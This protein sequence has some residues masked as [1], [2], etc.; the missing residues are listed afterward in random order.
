MCGVD[1]G[2]CRYYSAGFVVR[3]VSCRHNIERGRHYFICTHPP[4]HRMHLPNPCIHQHIPPG[5]VHPSSGQPCPVGGFRTSERFNS[6]PTFYPI[7]G[8]RVCPFNR[9]RFIYPFNRSDFESES[10]RNRDVSLLL[11]LFFPEKHIV[12]ICMT[13]KSW[14]FNS[15]FIVK[16]VKDS[17]NNGHSPTWHHVSDI[18]VRGSEPRCFQYR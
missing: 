12:P 3:G 9:S 2:D 16:P 14:N 8:S 1:S 11:L 6:K 15:H 5:I 18:F 4:I 17:K 10:A 7:I 13:Q